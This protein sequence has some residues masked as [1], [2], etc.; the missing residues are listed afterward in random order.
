MAGSKH[1]N[2]FHGNIGKKIG[3][4]SMVSLTC[5]GVKLGHATTKLG[6]R[7]D[8]PSFRGTDGIVKL[9]ATATESTMGT[10]PSGLQ[11]LGTAHVGVCK[12]GSS[13]LLRN[14]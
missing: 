6:I 12:I 3:W 1:F 9:T 14:T 8:T 10:P 13:S 2:Y 5:W 11:P 7:S 4:F